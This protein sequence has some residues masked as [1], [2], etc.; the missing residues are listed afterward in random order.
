MLLHDAIE[1]VLR[2]AGGPMHA[3]DI[4]VEIN[5]RQLYARRD[6]KLLRGNRISTRALA[7]REYRAGFVVRDGVV[8]LA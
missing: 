3:D 6:G 4:A 8:S 2:D 5:R 1:T 7:M